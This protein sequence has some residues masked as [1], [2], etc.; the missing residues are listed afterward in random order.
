MGVEWK[1]CPFCAEDIRQEAILCRYCGRELQVGPPPLAIPMAAP[2]KNVGCIPSL[3]LLLVSTLALSLTGAFARKTVLF[4][5]A[6]LAVLSLGSLFFKGL[7]ARLAGWFPV[8]AQLQFLSV[9]GALAWIGVACTGL[10]SAS[11]NILSALQKTRDF[12]MAVAEGASHLK[13]HRFRLAVERFSAAEKLGTL[14]AAQRASYGEAASGVA[15][16]YAQKKD[17]DQAIANYA[18]AKKQAPSLAAEVDKKST[19]AQISLLLGRAA[20]SLEHAQAKALAGRADDAERLIQQALV[21]YRQVLS[22]K[23]EDQDARSGSERA[24]T[25]LI[26]ATTILADQSSNE[27]R[28]LL[29]KMKFTE[30]AKA[31]RSSLTRYGAL[32]KMG[33]ESASSTTEARAALKKALLGLA[34]QGLANIRVSKKS[35][36]WQDV[37]SGGLPIQGYFDEA[38]SLEPLTSSEQ[39]LRSEVSLMISDANLQMAEAKR[40]AEELERRRGKEPGYMG[41]KEPVW[42]VRAYLEGNLKDPDSLQYI[43]WSHATPVDDYWL[44]RCKYRAKNSFGGYVVEERLFYIQQ[45]Q[46]VKVTEAQ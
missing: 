38:A 20:F 45:S 26:E 9:L 36:N 11:G 25:M 6:A 24:T 35:K 15:D 2:E 43:K 14:S 37:I 28:S 29:E 4:C 40:K 39:E 30:A 8:R 46:V 3:V 12:E 16:E 10:M 5:S 1:K 21:D 32:Q 27:G 31:F 13:D 19:E 18:L 22:L 41:I 42:P 17:W 23:P 44:V 7:R 34:Q 33:K